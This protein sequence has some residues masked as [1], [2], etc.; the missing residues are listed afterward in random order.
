MK[1]QLFRDMDLIAVCGWQGERCILDIFHFD[2]PKQT[3][4]N[5]SPSQLKFTGRKITR[6]LT[7]VYGCQEERSNVQILHY[8][9]HQQNKSNTSL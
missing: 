5:T 7:E 1:S 3:K 6:D 8:D 2:Y 4:S 9:N